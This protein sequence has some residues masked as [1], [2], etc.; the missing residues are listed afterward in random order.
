[1]TTYIV[2]AF[3]FTFRLVAIPALVS[4]ISILFLKY[5]TMSMIAT[6]LITIAVITYIFFNQDVEAEST[7]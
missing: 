5:S 3:S 6:S 7:L 1:M 4:I 2:N